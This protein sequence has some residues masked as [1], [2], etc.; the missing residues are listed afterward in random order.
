MGLFVF[1]TA[2]FF[3]PLQWLLRKFVLPKPGEGPSEEFMDSGFLKVTGY[4]TGSNGSKVKSMIY[5]PTDPGYRDTVLHLIL[6]QTT[7]DY[8]F[9]PYR[10]AC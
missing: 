9:P 5:F 2:F 1:G 3:P 6:L 8:L 4:G 10:H 7:I